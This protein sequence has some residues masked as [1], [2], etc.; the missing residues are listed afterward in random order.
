M[1]FVGQHE[2]NWTLSAHTEYWQRDPSNRL[3]SYK[4][5]HVRFRQGRGW[6]IY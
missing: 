1:F 6:Q 4:A 5:K 2:I 3:Y